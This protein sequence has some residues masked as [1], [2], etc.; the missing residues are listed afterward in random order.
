MH[1][2]SSQGADCYDAARGFA[3]FFPLAAF[4]EVRW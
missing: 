1:K 4:V 3:P 2:N